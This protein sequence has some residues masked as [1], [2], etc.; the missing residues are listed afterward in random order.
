MASTT[1]A[2]AG[3]GAPTARIWS[4]SIRTVVALRTCSPS[5]IRAFS[6]AVITAAPWRPR[7]SRAGRTIE[8][9]PRSMS[10]DNYIVGHIYLSSCGDL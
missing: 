3:A 9:R 1:R 7:M 10:S 8:R 5:K 6:I 4:P 2:A